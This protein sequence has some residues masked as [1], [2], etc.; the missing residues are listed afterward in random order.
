MSEH[1]GRERFAEELVDPD[2]FTIALGIFGAVA[3]RILS[4][5][6]TSASVHGAPAAG[7]V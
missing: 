1:Q 3:R 4:R 7:R 2:P 5:G 6:A